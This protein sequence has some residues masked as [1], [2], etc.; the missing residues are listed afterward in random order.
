MVVHLVEVSAKGAAGNEKIT[1]V[2]AGAFVKNNA[3]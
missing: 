1:L 2:A 3:V